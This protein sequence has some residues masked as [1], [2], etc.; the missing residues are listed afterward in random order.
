MDAGSAT[1]PPDLPDSPAPE[2]APPDPPGA[3]PDSPSAVETPQQRW[4]RKAT[5]TRLQATSI[6][7]VALLAYLVA[8]AAL[9]TGAVR[10]HWLF[11][12]SRVALVWIVL[13]AALIGWALG[14]LSIAAFHWRTRRPHRHS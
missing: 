13:F 3:L 5:R 6:A 14:L 9:N 7:A 10:A 12:T 1:N 2:S 4:R 11:G 8:L